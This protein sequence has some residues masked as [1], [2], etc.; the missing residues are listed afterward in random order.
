MVVTTNRP[1]GIAEYVQLTHNKPI[2]L[3][4]H[5]C[6][7]MNLTSGQKVEVDEV[8]EAYGHKWGVRKLKEHKEDYDCMCFVIEE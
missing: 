1:L 7:V 5:I 8:V 2:Q 4:D 6:I 3:G